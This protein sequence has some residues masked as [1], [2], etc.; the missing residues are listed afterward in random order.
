MSRE[1]YMCDRCGHKGHPLYLSD[2]EN[3]ILCADCEADDAHEKTLKEQ[4]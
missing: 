2:E 3:E 1:I 4:D